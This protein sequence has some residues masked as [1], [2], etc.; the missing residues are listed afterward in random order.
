MSKLIDDRKLRDA[1]LVRQ[2]LALIREK[3]IT[4]NIDWSDVFFD[5]LLDA[6]ATRPAPPVR[7][8]KNDKPHE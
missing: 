1:E 2:G 3:A 8:H 5:A 7:L 6:F 4:S